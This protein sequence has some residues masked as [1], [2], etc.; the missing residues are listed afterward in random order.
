MT[1]SPPPPGRELLAKG[2]ETTTRILEQFR[3]LTEVAARQATTLAPKPLAPPHAAL[4]LLA[5]S[6]LALMQDAAAYAVDATQRATLPTLLPD[7]S[8]RRRALAAVESVAG[9]EEELGDAAATMLRHVR[10]ALGVS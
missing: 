4:S 3:A 7:A 6:P 1:A 2:A 10:A 8:D 9:P 5:R